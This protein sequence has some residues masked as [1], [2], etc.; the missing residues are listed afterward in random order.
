MCRT[1]LEARDVLDRWG[2]NADGGGGDGTAAAATAPRRGADEDETSSVGERGAG[3]NGAGSG[4]GM[5]GLG[6]REVL[7]EL[8]ACPFPESSRATALMHEW[9]GLIEKYGLGSQVRDLRVAVDE[10]QTYVAEKVARMRARLAECERLCEQ[11]L[12]KETRALFKQQSQQPQLPVTTKT[13]QRY[14]RLQQDIRDATAKKER[15]VERLRI[16]EMRLHDLKRYH[17]AAAVTLNIGDHKEFLLHETRLL[18]RRREIGEHTDRSH[19]LLLKR[20]GSKREAAVSE[21]LQSFLAATKTLIDTRNSTESQAWRSLRALWRRHRPIVQRLEEVI[22]NHLPSP[23]ELAVERI[24]P[25]IHAL[26]SSAENVSLVFE[27]YMQYYR[28]RFC[29]LFCNEYIALIRTWR[30]PL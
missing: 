20:L 7:E 9:Q 29:S 2:K 28:R 15:A 23:A 30:A 14:H 10:Q 17:A 19:K 5:G 25:D 18:Q 8:S 13:A 12:A 16:Q 1:N 22:V 21:N 6:R 26:R 3:E 4:S 11:C 24:A 27:D